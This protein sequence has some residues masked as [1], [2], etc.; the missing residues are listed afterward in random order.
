MSERKAKLQ[1]V[2]AVLLYGTIGMLLRQIQ[3]PSELVVLCRGVIG[4][5]TILTILTCK[6]RKLNW[7]AIREN[8]KMLVIS[9][10]CLGLNWVLLFAAYRVTT[11]AIASLCNYMAPI[12]VVLLAPMFFGDK[13]TGKK[14]L[15]VAAAFCGIVLAAFAYS[16]LIR[17]F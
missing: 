16:L 1:Y 11:V 5:I 14:L 8:G 9:G 15:C 10:I 2:I 12:I 6:G 3:A 7:K 4:T 13:L 17:S